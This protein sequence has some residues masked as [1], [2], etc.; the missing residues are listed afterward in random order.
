[1]DNAAFIAEH[2]R[3]IELAAT[4]IAGMI[5]R[6]P[7]LR[8]DIDARLIL[9]AE[10]LQITGAFKLRGAFNAVLCLREREPDVTAVC[11]VSSGNHAQAVAYAARACG[12]HAVV[13][14]P[15]GATPAKVA[16]TLALGAEVISDGV[17]FDNR[18]EVVARLVAERGLPMIHPFDDWDV[19]HGQGTTGLELLSDHPEVEAIVAPVGG[20][21]ML[22]GVALAAHHRGADVKI[23][24][25][26]P[27]TADD[28][29]R[30]FATGTL[31][32]LPGTPRTIAEGV[33]VPAIGERN[34]DVLVQR[35]LADA[36]VTVS[37]DELRAA[38]SVLWRVGRLV[39]E[40][41]AALSLAAYR[42]GKLPISATG[43]VALVITGGNF[44]PADIRAIL[45]AS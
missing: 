25:V 43:S 23:I 38:L 36:I 21:G 7:A 33:R 22:S 18:D 17:T 13:V 40:P 34:F 1:M 44:D 5:R 41:T 14:I 37:E 30:S 20:G 10:N 31:Q 26:E 45:E 39:V 11:T 35:R 6:T 4:R 42:S 9:K 12:L 8:T 29:T 28:A 3:E 24:G 2:G 15:Q 27:E 32:R 16:A 19:I